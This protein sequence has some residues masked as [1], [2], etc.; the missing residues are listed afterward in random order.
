MVGLR[1]RAFVKGRCPGLQHGNI[2]LPL[3]RG[4]EV[5]VEEMERVPVYLSGGVRALKCPRRPLALMP[6]RALWC[7]IQK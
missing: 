1:A 6:C 3:N 2:W 7:P 5:R 4:F